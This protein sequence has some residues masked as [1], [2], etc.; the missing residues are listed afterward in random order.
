MARPIVLGNGELH[1]GIND[2]GLVHD[3]HFPH[4]GLENHTIGQGLRHKIGVW[5]AGEISW[6]D[7][8]SWYLTFDYPHES[9]IGHTVARNDAKQV[10][11]EFDDA[12]DS[13]LNV[14]M[15]S[16]HVVNTASEEREIRL[17]TH[18]AFVIGDS[19]GNTDTAQYL[20]DTD[21]IMHYRGRRVFLISG[22][23]ENQLFDQHTVGLF[24]IEGHEGSWRDADDGELSGSSSEHGRVDSVLR[25][26][27]TIGAHS[28]SRV[29]YWIAAGTSMRAA[30]MAHKKLREATMDARFIATASWWHDWLRPT[31]KASLRLPVRWRR[32]FVVSAMVL[33]SQ[34]DNRGA[35]I[36]STDSAM[37]NYNRD[38]YAYCWP[39]DGAYIVWPL[40]RLGYTDEVERFFDFCRRV[41]HPNGYLSHKYRSD[42]ALGSSWHTYVHGERVAPPIQTDETALVLFTFSQYYHQHK[43][44]KLLT[45]YYSTFV[46]P[47]ADFLTG[48]IDS[49]TNLPLPSYDLWEERFIVSTY[50]TSVT[51]ASLL[52]AADL[53]EEFGD[54][55]SAVAWRSAAEDMYQAAHGRFYNQDRKSLRKGLIPTDDGYED[56]NSIDMSAIFGAFM[57]GLYD[58]H[59]PII[60]D[61]IDTALREFKQDER[62]GLPRYE[63]DAYR[64]EPGEK[65]GNFWHITTLWY[66]QY[67][68]EHDKIKAASELIDWSCKHSYASGVMAEQIIPESGY[69]TSVAPLAWSHAEFMATLLD[70][71]VN[72]DQDPA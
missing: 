31:T 68:L 59:D 5:I 32:Q 50:T 52:A 25:F 63:D 42:G 28:S 44:E 4:V 24:G 23:C 51:F 1:V 22:E 55:D 14:F 58:V 3:F 47:M 46:K 37:L 70:Y 6:L 11:L 48:Y 19:R 67:L 61:S 66:A 69:S 41:L 40:M 57:F 64:R 39:R 33:R 18:Q 45:E 56:D 26:R 21:A 65:I 34:M 54:Q 53:A 15:R 9:L 62:I 60:T 35:I 27:M 71:M 10:I 13:E 30:I 72:E 7:D 29:R 8:G 49:D 17:F 16:I 2:Y 43:S 20:P 36:A 38:A 12:V